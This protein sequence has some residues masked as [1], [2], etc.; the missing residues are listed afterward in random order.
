M[1]GWG[2]GEGKERETRGG[3][4]EDKRVDGVIYKEKKEK[5]KR[6]VRGRKKME[7]SRGEVSEQVNRTRNRRQTRSR[8][9][10]WGG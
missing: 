10:A 8:R 5:E 3:A 2:G 9:R 1:K 4:T 7:G 6:K